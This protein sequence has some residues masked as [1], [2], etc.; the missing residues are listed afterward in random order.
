M[1]K[2]DPDVVLTVE[3]DRWWEEALRALE[4]DY[5]Y[6][7]KK[8]LDNAFGMIVHSR[9]EMIDPRIRF[10]LKDSIPS[11]HLQVVLPSNDRVFMHFVHP[12]RPTPSMPPRR[13]SG[14]R[15][16]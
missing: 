12:T 10:I 13:R 11:M 4:E 14:T 3:T 5:P 2:Y 1:R 7:L 6:T 15:S 8:P 9:L 16:C